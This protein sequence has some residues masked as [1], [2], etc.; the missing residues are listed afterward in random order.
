MLGS[1][2]R[3]GV[4]RRDEGRRGVLGVGG[5]RSSGIVFVVVVAV[6][7]AVLVVR[8]VLSGVR[9]LGRRRR[10]ICLVSWRIPVFAWAEALGRQFWLCGGI[11]QVD[12]DRWKTS[13][14]PVPVVSVH[15][16]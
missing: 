3:R 15:P 13:I 14:P 5:L 12:R 10:R 1:G 16:T 4:R 11:A 6:A 2:R 9:V 7:V 8:V